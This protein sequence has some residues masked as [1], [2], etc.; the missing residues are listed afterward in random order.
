[1]MADMV[2]TDWTQVLANEYQVPDDR[3]L[4]ELTAELTTMLGDPNPQA[5]DGVAFPVLATW[6]SEGVYDDLLVGLGDGMAAGLLTG[7]GEQGTDSVFRRTFSVLVL[8]C[9]IERDTEEHLLP[10]EQVLRWGDRIVG[11]YL[12]E[13]DLRG[14]VPGHGWA[15]AV[16]HGADALGALAA[17][18]HLTVAELTVLLDVVAD[19]ALSTT[20]PLL[21]GEPDRMASAVL[22]ILRRNLVPVAVVEPWI[23]RIAEHANPYSPDADPD[24]D[25]YGPTTNAQALLRALYLQLAFGDRPPADRSDLLLVTVDALRRTNPYT[26][27]S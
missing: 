15:H 16:A 2:A 19:R 7:L 10:G 24:R 9:V 6:V 20:E 13:S 3:S 12:R 22:E 5:R 18:H 4:P 11:W 1:M 27:K 26:L 17:S 21:C 8:G 14:F 23:A 25:P